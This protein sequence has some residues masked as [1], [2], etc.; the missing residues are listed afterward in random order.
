MC[1]NSVRIDNEVT[2][3]KVL[4]EIIVQFSLKW[5]IISD[6]G[7]IASLEML[8]KVLGERHLFSFETAAV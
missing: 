4:A 6:L 3:T 1:P 8:S 7:E 5:K 2:S